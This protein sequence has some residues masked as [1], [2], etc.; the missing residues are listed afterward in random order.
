M[1]PPLELCAQVVLTFLL[2]SLSLSL[3]QIELDTN[4]KWSPAF[5]EEKEKEKKLM[6]TPDHWSGI[7]KAK[8]VKGWL[9]EI[10]RNN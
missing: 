6:M 7:F 5:P 10:D 3:S 8:D 1:S 9:R 2:L 4:R